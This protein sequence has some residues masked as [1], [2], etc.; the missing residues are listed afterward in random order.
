MENLGA[1]FS[2]T[3]RLHHRYHHSIL[4]NFGI[5]RGQPQ[6]FFA[7]NQ[8]E[9]SINQRCLAKKMN[10][11]PSTLTR[12]AQA[13]EKRGYV[14]RHSDDHDQRQTLISLTSEGRKVHDQIKQQ[15][16]QID[17]QLFRNFTEA[18]Q[19]QIRSY[20]LRIQKQLVE[21]LKKEGRQ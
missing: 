21:E 19:S 18:E 9:G 5:F 3:A 20:L 11:S 4:D 14:T 13:L 8:E 2:R 16:D 10:I 12:M 1:V 15:F 6:L 17:K 7:L